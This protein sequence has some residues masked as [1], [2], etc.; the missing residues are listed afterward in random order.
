MKKIINKKLYDTDTARYV[1]THEYGRYDDLTYYVSDLYVKKTGEFFAF[2]RGN[3]GSIYA[4]RIDQ[5]TWADGETI[6]P[7]TKEQARDWLEHFAPAEIYLKYF[8]A[9]E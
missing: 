4:K 9:E 5:N 2:A 3:A 8:N 6:E 7:L 1:Y